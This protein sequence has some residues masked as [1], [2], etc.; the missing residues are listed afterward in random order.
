MRRI[1]LFTAVA[2][3]FTLIFSQLWVSA[4]ACTAVG[5]TKQVVQDATVTLSANHLD[6]RDPHTAASCHLHC[7]N[8]AQPDHADLPTLSPAV[9]LPL[10]WG[11]SSILELAVRPERPSHP[12][13]ILLSAPPPHRILFQV[14]RT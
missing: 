12:E 6:L 5:P 2:V 4:Y 1:K 13:P 3:L 10:A 8:Q 11:H 7:N 9:W 14:F